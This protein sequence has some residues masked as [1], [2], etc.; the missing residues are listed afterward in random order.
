[1]VISEARLHQCWNFLIIKVVHRK[2]RHAINWWKTSAKS[3]LINILVF[4]MYKELLEIKKITKYYN[5]VKRK[6]W[7]NTST[8]MTKKLM[9]SMW[10]MPL[11]RYHRDTCERHVKDV[12]G[13]LAVAVRAWPDNPSDQI[14][15]TDN[16]SRWGRGSPEGF[17]H[18]WRKCRTN[19]AVS[20]KTKYNLIMRF[21]DYIPCYLPKW[22]KT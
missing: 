6:T 16:M 17:I 20:Y 22:I 2:M 1:M 4:K 14:H 12:I 13:E 21:S 9:E 18:C 7:M 8:K 19:L 10:K 11:G 15:T 3:H 5:P